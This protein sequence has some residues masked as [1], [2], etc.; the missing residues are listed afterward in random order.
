LPALENDLTPTPMTCLVKTR[1][2]IG[3]RDLGANNRR[4]IAQS[5]ATP[6]APCAQ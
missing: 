1:G 3:R 4:E 2:L 5:Y 6:P